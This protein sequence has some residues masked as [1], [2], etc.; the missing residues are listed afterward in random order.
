MGPLSLA[1]ILEFRY[2]KNRLRCEQKVESPDFHL[3]LAYNFSFFKSA[4][5]LTKIF[6]F[7]QA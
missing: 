6:T 3:R 7:S 4:D 5:A 2:I 1:A